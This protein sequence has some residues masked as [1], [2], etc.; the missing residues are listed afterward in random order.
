MEALL[1]RGDKIDAI[2]CANDLL[3]LGALKTLAKRGIA[4]PGEV[5]IV[6]V[7]DIEEAS[8]A[9]PSLSSVFIDRTW[10]RPGQVMSMSDHCWCAPPR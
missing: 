1:E 5:A 9:N 2:F 8:Y 4:V 6:A 10:M 7:D 3:A